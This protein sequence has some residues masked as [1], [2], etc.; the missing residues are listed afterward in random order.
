MESTQ[1]SA[2]FHHRHLQEDMVY[3]Q[4]LPAAFLLPFI[5]ATDY[6]LYRC[7]DTSNAILI[8]SLFFSPLQ[9]LGLNPDF[10]LL[11]GKHYL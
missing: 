7:C 11:L 6:R 2:P 4:D 8:S 5:D 10:V 3:K 9:Y 1:N